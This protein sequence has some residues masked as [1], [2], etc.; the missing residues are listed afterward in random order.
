MAEERSAVQ[1]ASAQT[2]RSAFAR[3]CAYLNYRAAAKWTAYISAV[4]TALLFVVLLV[5]LT[6]FADLIVNR[7]QLPAFDDLTPAEQERVLAGRDELT[8][9]ERREL[10][11]P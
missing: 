11:E 2:E 10:L 8:P 3:A 9:A 5:L 6:L 7:G 1:P 4:L